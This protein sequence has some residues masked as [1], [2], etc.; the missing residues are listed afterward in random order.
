MKYNGEQ[1]ALYNRVKTRTGTIEHLRWDIARDAA[2]AEEQGV[3]AWAEIISAA[4]GREPSTVYDWRRAWIL[5]KSAKPKS[6][7]SISFWVT[8]ANGITEE[9][10]TAVLDWLAEC[11]QGGITL[12]AARRQFP[13]SMKGDKPLDGLLDGLADKISQIKTRNDAAIIDE[14]LE[15]ALVMLRVARIKLIGELERETA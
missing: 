15:I 5:R 12:E 13:R 11:E 3:E 4:C 9:N 10:Y 14:Q 2:D 6:S 1:L 8:A 7:L